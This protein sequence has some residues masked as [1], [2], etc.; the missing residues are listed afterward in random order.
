[1][2]GACSWPGLQPRGR[3]AH[4]ASRAYSPGWASTARARRGAAGRRPRTGC[5][6]CS[7]P[8]GRCR[9]T[10]SGATGCRCAAPTCAGAVTGASA[11][12]GSCV[13]AAG[14]RRFTTAR[15]LAKKDLTPRTGQQRRRPVLCRR[16]A[17]DARL[18][19]AAAARNRGHGHGLRS[20]PGR[21]SSRWARPGS[22][23]SDAATSGL[24]SSAPRPLGPARRPALR[25]RVARGQGA[26]PRPL[27]RCRPRAP[28]AGRRGIPAAH[29]AGLGRGSAA[30]A[31]AG[32][33]GPTTPPA[34]A[35][36]ICLGGR[37]PARGR[38]SRLLPAGARRGCG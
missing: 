37:S 15:D 5:A 19:R 8:P 22:P 28:A 3:S 23:W 13:A 29:A 33:R 27:E 6:S 24:R 36:W 7:A 2:T 18:R 4:S 21:R 34:R 25:V 16:H 12:R 20:R 14:H 35:G 10:S 32:L 30:P 9:G 17:D 38:A 11:P 1:L 26:P 31:A